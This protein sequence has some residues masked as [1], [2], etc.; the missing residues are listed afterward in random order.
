MN[1]INIKSKEKRP[2]A[3]L[4]I[5]FFGIVATSI[6]GSAVRDAAFLVQFDKSLLPIMYILIALTMA[7]VITVYKKMI[8]EKDQV[9][10]ITVTGL[11]FSI[12]L[13]LIQSNL[14]GFIIPSFYV[15]MEVITI[16][17]ILQFWVLAGEVFNTRQAKRIFSLITIGGSFAGIGVGYSI[18]PFVKYY[19]ADNLLSLTIFFIGVTVFMAQL[20]RPYRQHLTL[21]PINRKPDNNDSQVKLTPYL[22]SIAIMVGL[23]AFISKIIDYQFKIMAVNAYPDQNE[24]VSF[25]GTYYMSTGAA[26]LIMQ[27]FITGFILTRF[28]ILAGLLVLPICLAI[29]STSFFLMGTI[30]TVFFAKFSDQVFK[31]ST[32]NAVQEILWLPV[33]SRNKRQSKPIIDGTIRSGMEGLAGLIIFGIVSANLI[34]ESKIYLLSLL[35]LF[36]I[37]LWLWNNLKL[38]NG[39]LSSLMLSIENRQLNLDNVKFDINDSHIVDTLEKTLNNKDKFKQLFA[40]DLLWTLPLSP[41]EKTLKTMFLSGSSEIKRGVLELAWNQSNI[42]SND[43]IISQIEP[44][45]ELSPFLISC[46]GDRDI[47]DLQQTLG[48]YI[49]SSN[50]GLRSSSAVSI[51][52]QY[53]N[54]KSAQA[55]IDSIMDSNDQKALLET[56]GFIKS[57]NVMISEENILRLLGSHSDEIKIS[58]LK[59][60]KHRPNHI[61]LE[62]VVHLLSRPSTYKHAKSALIKFNDNK[63]LKKMK[64]L[65][66]KPSCS[67]ELKVGIL[68]TIYHFHGHETI[69][70]I[71]SKIHDPELLILDAAS[72]AL[73]KLSKN[74]NLEKTELSK[75]NDAVSLIAKRTYQLYQ[76]KENLKQVPNAILLLDH[77]DSDIDMLIPILL[78]LGTLEYPEIPIE[79]YIRY[80]KSNDKELLPIVLELIE[81]TFSNENRRVTLPLIDLEV[82]TIHSGHDLFPEMIN[83][84]D[85]MLIFWIENSHYWKTSIAIHFLLNKEN[86]HVLKSINWSFIPES[87]FKDKLFNQSEQEYL[88]RNFLK[89]KLPKQEY[90]TMYSILE[91]TIILKSVDLFN[92]IP[93]DVLNKIAQISEEIQYQKGSQIFYE[94]ENGDSMFVIISGKIDITQKGHSITVLERGHCIGEMALLDQEPRSADAS[95]LEDSIL[96]KID[97]EGF[98]E[99]MA[100]NREIMKQIV[101]IL[102]R[103]VRNMNEKLTK[104]LK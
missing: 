4:L 49:N 85:R 29:G 53:P 10:V 22:R 27:L 93:G 7:G 15:W 89:N 21:T 6:T 78:K 34:P 20:I 99:L 36:G 58:I 79:T 56:L 52:K 95:T 43:M 71:I 13:F 64:D 67:I 28:G 92:L 26:T 14:S 87:I 77:L 82:D 81:S 75:V 1:I 3:L 44:E 39:Y 33:S 24:L 38:K 12:S 83:S 48:K 2:A 35:V 51:L 57:P 101:K 30:S 86:M 102:T 55:A 96:L 47:T 59:I 91:K 8:F 17:S 66:N 41:W 84:I 94:G 32:N 40:L 25:F 104:S 11:I 80:V 76:F 100:T 42:I 90:P 62:P 69:D 61:F 31:F 37:I 88:Y 73:V 63:A 98:Y 60:I 5:M 54:N 9:T 23:S 65:L 16:L 50:I 74:T 68:N 45:N 97:Q 46:A 18:K 103:R 19:G 70:I 72:N